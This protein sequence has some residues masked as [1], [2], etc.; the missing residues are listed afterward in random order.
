MGI[1]YVGKGL[2]R[3]VH[4]LRKSPSNRHYAH[5]VA[6]YGAENVAIDFHLCESEQ[7]A[8]DME[9]ALIA[10]LR[11][12]GAELTN[13][14]DGGE[15]VT[16]YRFSAEAVEHFRATTQ[17]N[18]QDP[19]Y[20]NKT[21]N[22]RVGKLSIRTPAKLEAACA[23]AE[24][25]RAALQDPLMKEAARLKNSVH[26]KLVW[27]NPEFRSKMQVIRAASWTEERRA[28]KGSQIRGRVR[29]TNGTIERN[30]LLSEVSQLEAVG[31]QRGRKPRNLL[32]RPEHFS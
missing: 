11:G 17:A 10:D 31:W 25:A 27:S 5:V 28:A 13:L 29:V 21:L 12:I 26:S 1:F 19:E 14:T 24:K 16:G 23:N 22:A 4:C 15:G 7:D 2:K 30:V 9:Q 20:R 3:R 18:W 32:S 6:K 8:L